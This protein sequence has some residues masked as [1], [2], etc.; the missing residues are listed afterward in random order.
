MIHAKRHPTRIRGRVKA[1]LENAP[2]FGIARRAE[3]AGPAG[4][5]A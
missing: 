3:C 1:S 4:S 2:A 5:L